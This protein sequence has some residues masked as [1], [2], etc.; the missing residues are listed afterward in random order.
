MTE[1]RAEIFNA[2]KTFALIYI[3]EVILAGKESLEN[4]QAQSGRKEPL[5]LRRI[6]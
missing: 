5:T 3:Y 4:F 2:R 6:Q 1:I